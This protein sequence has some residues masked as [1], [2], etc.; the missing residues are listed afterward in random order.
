MILYGKKAAVTGGSKGIGAAAAV[1]LAKEGADLLLIGREKENLLSVQS[2]IKSLGRECEFIQMDVGNPEN[3]KR[4]EEYLEFFGGLDIYVNNAAFT[5]RKSFME[6]SYDEMFSLF[7]TNFFGASLMTQAAARNM[8]KNGRG[9]VIT[10]VTSINAVSALPSQAIYSCTKAALESMMK[11][12][13]AELAP[14]GIRVNSVAPGAILTDMNDNYTPEKI[15]EVE[16]SIALGR[17]GNVDEIADVI[18]FL[19]SSAAR[20]LTGSTIIADGGSLLRSI[21]KPTE[22]R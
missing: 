19:C 7:K 14:Y 15:A 16:K 18:L 1:A 4:F 20:Y 3:T 11:S 10:I 13:A 17:V 22:K 2:Q 21:G 9:G 12:L 8:K 6:T 5:M